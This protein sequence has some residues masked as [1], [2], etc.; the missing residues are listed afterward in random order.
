MAPASITHGQFLHFIEPILS[1]LSS[2]LIPKSEMFLG[3]GKI[4]GAWL[5]A[6]ISPPQSPDYS[7]LT[8][9]STQWKPGSIP[10]ELKGSKC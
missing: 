2:S 8:Q 3:E 1:Q 6:L 5:L 10:P 4:P 9:H 7:A